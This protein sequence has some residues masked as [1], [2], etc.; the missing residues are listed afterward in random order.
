MF[1]L[2]LTRALILQL[3]V[4]LLD[5]PTSALDHIAAKAIEQLLMELKQSCTILLVSLYID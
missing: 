3:E 2:R 4:F 5:E 1:R